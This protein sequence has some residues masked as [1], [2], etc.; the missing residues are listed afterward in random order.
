MC[1]LVTEN[2]R[3]ECVCVWGGG[4]GGGLQLYQSVYQSTEPSKTARIVFRS[5]SITSYK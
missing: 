1:P 5:D 4:G 3:G 2:I